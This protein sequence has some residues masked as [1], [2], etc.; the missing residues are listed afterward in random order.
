MRLPRLNL[1]PTA[2]GVALALLATGVGRADEDDTYGP[3]IA[4][5]SER[6]LP[7]PKG[8]PKVV[9]DAG[10]ALPKAVPPE[11]GETLAKYLDAVKAKKWPKAREL[12]HP[13]TLKAI[14]QIKKRLGE[15]RHSM[16]PWYWAST[17]TL[18]GYKV[19]DLNPATHGFVAS[20]SEDNYQVQE[21]GDYE[22]EKSAYLLGK[23]EGRWYVV[24]KKSE[25]DG[26][27][28]D[29]LKYGYSNY[30]DKD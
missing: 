4:I 24:D 11:A 21:K 3:G 16:A 19:L 17:F 22:G 23:Y 12:T 14:A 9:P 28:N 7:K 30:F 18:K 1:A 2:L 15:E 27:T 13:L 5:K 20:V 25:A 6:G 26:F 10:P 29:S 8:P